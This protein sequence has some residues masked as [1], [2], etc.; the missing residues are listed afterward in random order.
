MKTLIVGARGYIGSRL[1][2]HLIMLG[3]DVCEI[4]YDSDCIQPQ[5]GLL[6]HDYMLPTGCDSIIYLAQSPYYRKNNQNPLQLLTVSV[7]NAVRLAELAVN[8]GVNRYIYT[9]TGNVYAPSFL[10]LHEGFPLRRDNWYSLSKVHAEEALAQFHN[11]LSITILRPFGIYGP[12][13]TDKLVPNILGR[14]VNGQNILIDQNPNDTF[15]D[16]GL[17]LSLCYIDDIVRIIT[18]LLSA[19]DMKNK[20]LNV[21]GPE[22]YSV[23][24]IAECAGRLLGITPTFEPSGNTREFDLIADV[25]LL[26]QVVK[27]L[28]TTFEDGLDAAVQAYCNFVAQGK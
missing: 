24:N 28:Y 1:V 23:R 4:E 20:I 5:N 17:R 6:V 9:S 27:P 15:D 22:H 16:G 21:A 13:Q 7:L 14:L 11:D 19:V 18:E 10:P 12:N 3:H 25:S 2:K 8:A 26:H